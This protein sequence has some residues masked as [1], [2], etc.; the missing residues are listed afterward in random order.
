[1]SDVAIALVAAVAENDVIG[2]AGDMPWRL[3]SDLR[4][5]K[6]LTLGHP[7]VMGRRT[8]ASIGRPLPGRDNIVVSRNPAF[9][10]DGVEAASS[11]DAGLA[12]AFAAARKAGLDTVFV[13]G[14]G[15]LYAAAMERADRLHITHVAA[16]PEGDTHFPPIDPAIW[17][18]ESEERVAAGE[19]DTAATRYVVYRR[20]ISAASR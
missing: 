5:F 10:A 17:E 20:R 15:E 9:A 14:G 18:P 19:K 2:T 8:F 7:V 11:L 12:L 4:R 3:S 6:A 16:S 1:M 13:I